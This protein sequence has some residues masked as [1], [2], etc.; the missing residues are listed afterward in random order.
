MAPPAI[1]TRTRQAER[2]GEAGSAPAQAGMPPPAAARAVGAAVSAAELAGVG[3]GGVGAGAAGVRGDRAEP[4]FALGLQAPPTYSLP[5][6]VARG[7]EDVRLAG[8]SGGGGDSS[9][10]GFQAAPAYVPAAAVARGSGGVRLAGPFG[11]GDGVRLA[12]PFGGGD[13]QAPFSSGLEV[14]GALGGVGVGAAGVGVGRTEPS[15]IGLQAAAYVSPAGARGLEGVRLPGPFGGGDAPAGGAG[16]LG[17]WGGVQS[18]AGPGEVEAL[19]RRLTEEVRRSGVREQELRALR[20]QSA[21]G[22]TPA[23][24]ASSSRAAGFAGQSFASPVRLEAPYDKMVETPE[25]GWSA[26][27]IME[28]DPTTNTVRVRFRS[29]FHGQEPWLSERLVFPLDPTA[30]G[31]RG[32]IQRERVA[33]VAAPGAYYDEIFVST[34]E[35]EAVVSSLRGAQDVEAAVAAVALAPPGFKIAL[36]RVTELPVQMFD[37]FAVH[38][39]PQDV[40]PNSML[41]ALGRARTSGVLRV[42]ASDSPEYKRRAMLAGFGRQVGGMQPLFGE[43][44]AYALH[45]DVPAAS[46]RSVF[47]GGA[48]QLGAQGRPSQDDQLKLMAAML[49]RFSAHTNSTLAT[50]LEKLP[51]GGQERDDRDETTELKRAKNS[52]L[53][54]LDVSS[55]GVNGNFDANQ[56]ALKRLAN[57]ATQACHDASSSILER[58]R[59]GMELGVIALGATLATQ[60]ADALEAS[61]LSQSQPPTFEKFCTYMGTV[62]V[63]LVLRASTPEALSKHKHQAAVFPQGFSAIRERLER[64]AW[65]GEQSGQALATFVRVVL[66]ATVSEAERRSLA[67]AGLGAFMARERTEA[68]ASVGLAAAAGQ[69]PAVVAAVAAVKTPRLA[70]QFFPQ[71]AQHVGPLGR[72]KTS[73]CNSCQQVGHDRFECPMAFREAAGGY[74]MPGHLPSGEKV[75]NYWHDNSPSNGPAAW[76]AKEWI[77]HA[78]TAREL[79]GRDAV[80]GPG[81]GDVWAAWANEAQARPLQ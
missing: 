59:E 62:F 12:G 4:A 8:P 2:E 63:I 56:I 53:E 41:Q 19:Q 79:Q 76:V 11:G 65:A 52:P 57:A 30:L 49:D 75:A 55:S 21:A 72:L 33:P 15:L 66:G 46:P 74:E 40:T 14:G 23:A 18:Q 50:L 32:P 24:A 6:A 78:W 1:R 16:G 44:P 58:N 5:A 45:G 61:K 48:G 20:Q 35:W 7:L 80:R 51:R 69:G 68:A 77:R 42:V 70:S 29:V 34:R 81:G 38:M 13:A 17:G 25:K 64:P 27:R 39:L 54:D 36:C 9:A 47:G 10:P 71:A 26:C 67:A 22:R 31:K 28:H 60:R 43:P 37:D 73:S 3:V